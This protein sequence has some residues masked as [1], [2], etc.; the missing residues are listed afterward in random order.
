[1]LAPRMTSPAEVLVHGATGFTGR[2]VC[3]ALQEKQIAFAVSGRSEAKL[4]ALVRSL[5]G[6]VASHVVDI[7][8]PESIRRAIDGRRIVCACA[9][10]FLEVGE[11]V[12]AHC[13]RAG[14]HYVDTTGEQ[15]FVARAVARHHATAEASGACVVPALGYEI[16]LADWAAHIATEKGDGPVVE[17]SICYGLRTPGGPFASRGTLRSAIAQFA[18]GD[19]MQFVDGALVREP[20]AEKVR[21]FEME[22][23]GRANEARACVSFPG[24]EAVVVSSHTGARTVRTFMPVGSARLL[25][26]ARRMVPMAAKVAGRLLGRLIARAPEGPDEAARARTWFEIL[27]EVERAGGRSVVRVVGH[28]PYGLTGEIQ[29]LAAERAVSGAVTARGVVA[30]SVAFDPRTSLA[31]LSSAGVSLR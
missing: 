17:I 23:L 10:P 21:T 14:V 30:P 20:A 24:P 26:R 3:R 27:V 1:M 15:A 31:A 25:H 6:G 9:G 8:S 19:A 29:A 28:D 16:A 11:P 4:A 2:L 12:L 5:G 7:G 13:A 22:T 18:S